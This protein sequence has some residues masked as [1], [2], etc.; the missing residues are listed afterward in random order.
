MRA[1]T[2]SLMHARMKSNFSNP[3][4]FASS[5][6][7]SK[8]KNPKKQKSCQIHTKLN[9]PL[10]CMRVAKRQFLAG[11]SSTVIIDECDTFDSTVDSR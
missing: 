2:P 4:F 6:S 5:P 11:D 8:E 9:S 10:L 1:G 3:V 7:S